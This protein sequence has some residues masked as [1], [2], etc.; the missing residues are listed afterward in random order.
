MRRKWPSSVAS[1]VAVIWHLSPKPAKSTLLLP[2][3]FIVHFPVETMIQTQQGWLEFCG[4]SPL[5]PLLEIGMFHL[6]ELFLVDECF[7]LCRCFYFHKTHAREERQGPVMGQVDMTTTLYKQNYITSSYYPFCSYNDNTG[8]SATSSISRLC[9]PEIFCS[10]L[11]AIMGGHVS[12][13]LLP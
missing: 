10:T 2:S 13:A 7:G 5:I 11:Q 6:L 3:F 1:K 9:M 4:T 12:L 8:V